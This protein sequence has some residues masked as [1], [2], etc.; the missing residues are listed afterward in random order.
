MCMCELATQRPQADCG[1]TRRWT[2]RVLTARHRWCLWSEFRTTSPTSNRRLSFHHVSTIYKVSPCFSCFSFYMPTTCQ[3]MPTDCFNSAFLF[4]AVSKFD[5]S[6]NRKRL[7]ECRI[8]CS[9]VGQAEDPKDPVHEVM[10]CH[11][12]QHV[13]MAELHRIFDPKKCRCVYVCFMIYN[14]LCHETLDWYMD[15]LLQCFNSACGTCNFTLRSG[16]H[17][18]EQRRALRGGT[19][20]RM[21]Y[22]IIWVLFKVFFIFSQ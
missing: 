20:R 3:Q 21:E 15:W 13:P 8:R 4:F 9:P 19:L 12:E 5:L 6:K 10:A 2:E 17:P 11:G 1:L 22:T 7:C 18:G 16:K 14:G